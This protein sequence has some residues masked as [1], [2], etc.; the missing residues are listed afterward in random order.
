MLYF[1]IRVTTLVE[2]HPRRIHEFWE[3]NLV[4]T[5]RGDVILKLSLSHG[6]MLSKM[7]K[8]NS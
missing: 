1:T 5:F 4:C 2:T 7:K 3:A 6:P 8:E